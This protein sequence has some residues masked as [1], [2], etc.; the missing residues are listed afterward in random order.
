MLVHIMERLVIDQITVNGVGLRYGICYQYLKEIYP[1]FNQRA[2]HYKDLFQANRTR[3]GDLVEG[4]IVHGTVSNIN[5][6][7][8]IFVSLGKYYTG[9]IHKNTLRR[10]NQDISD[11]RRGQTIE[12][13]ILRITL[14]NPPKFDLEPK[15]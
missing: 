8:G 10:C 1:D 7:F 4:I 2:D 5:P 14:G 13:R 9:L 6:K 3:V 12:V 15:K 11:F